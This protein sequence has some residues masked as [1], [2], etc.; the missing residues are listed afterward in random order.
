MG[1]API[2]VTVSENGAIKCTV[3]LIERN[4]D[5]DIYYYPEYYIIYPAGIND[6]NPDYQSDPNRVRIEY[7]WPS[8]G[9]DM[10][11]YSKVS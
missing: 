2:S 8:Q 3:R 4:E 1:L 9:V 10:S 11:M 7:W 5:D 6:N